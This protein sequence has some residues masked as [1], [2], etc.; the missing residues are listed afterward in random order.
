MQAELPPEAPNED[1]IK[2][3]KQHFFNHIRS[4]YAAFMGEISKLP[5]APFTFQRAVD[6]FNDGILW[7]KELIEIANL[8]PQN[9]V[10]EMPD[11]MQ[12]VQSEIKDE[13][14]LK[15]VSKDEPTADAA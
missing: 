13:I 14:E 15:E 9:P 10:S 3:A 12:E 2:L 6:H 11:Q 8:A 7:M 1:Q 5:Y 4:Q